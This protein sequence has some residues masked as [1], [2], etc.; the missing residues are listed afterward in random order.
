[1]A[2]II[3]P[4]VSKRAGGSSYVS[5]SDFFCGAGG[6]S[7]GAREAGAEIVVAVNHSELALKTH[8]SNFPKTKH[9][10]T[11]ITTAD[12]SK[13]PKTTMLLASPSCKNQSLAKGQRRKSK[14]RTAD[15]KDLFGNVLIDLDSVEERSR[16]T[17]LD[18]VRFAEE[19][20]YPLIIVE[21]VPEVVSWSLFPEWL[22]M[23]IKLG[24]N[25][26]LVSL[27][28]MFCHPTP[29]SRDRFYGVFWRR[30]LFGK[31]APDLDFFPKAPC[32][33]CGRDVDAVQS[34]KPKSKLPYQVGRYRR[35]YIYCCPS[36]GREVTPYFYAAFNC[37]DWTLP[38][39]RIGD[40]KQPLAPKTIQ[41]IRAGIR[42]F[43]RQSSFLTHP[44]Q[45]GIESRNL[46]LANAPCRT[47]TTTLGPALVTPSYGVDAGSGSGSASTNG[48]G[49]AS[50]PASITEPS[51]VANPITTTTTAAAAT[52]F[53]MDC[54]AEYRERSAVN[55][56]LSTIVAGGNHQA[57][58]LPGFSPFSPS[59]TAPIG[60]TKPTAPSTSFLNESQMAHAALIVEYYRTGGVRPVGA[61]PLSTVVAE[62]NHHA[63]ILPEQLQAFISSYY[64]DGGGQNQSVAG[65]PLGAVTTK[66]RHSLLVGAGSGGGSG[67]GS[68]AE[69]TDEELNNWCFRML[70]PHE[71]QRAMAFSDDYIVCGNAKERVGQLGD[72]VTPPAMTLL[73]KRC[74]EFLG[75][76]QP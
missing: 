40:R 20:Q 53:M 41:R 38:I 18:V 43:G 39:D 13:F 65:A 75:Y 54:I 63:L 74:M 55:A 4:W 70:Y 11:D 6:T 45:T 46:D 27:N 50:A 34:F 57:V 47:Q 26:R 64:G 67:S 35:Q 9:V 33:P 24:Y 21:N 23:M 30:D 37:I 44:N 66:E 58:V 16:A 12:A 69:V 71:I 56:P 15:H 61:A 49:T 31:R 19:H 72:A 62:G 7:A 3:A 2:T 28:S 22:A 52:P 59:L 42:Q 8:G 17:M 25:H 1:M 29:Q 36:C 73:V 10:L 76:F 51:A 60:A 32:I 5:A 48:S 68:A 14:Y